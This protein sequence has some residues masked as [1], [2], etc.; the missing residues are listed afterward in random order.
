MLLEQMAFKM[1]A[2]FR[3]HATPYAAEQQTY[4]RLRQDGLLPAGGVELTNGDQTSV[5][6][7]PSDGETHER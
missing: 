5:L 2:A 3:N 4:E 6:L 7:G 1:E